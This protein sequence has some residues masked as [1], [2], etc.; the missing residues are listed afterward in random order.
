MGRDFTLKQKYTQE[1]VPKNGQFVHSYFLNACVD[2][3]GPIELLVE[4]RQQEVD[5]EH[6]NDGIGEG[7]AGSDYDNLSSLASYGDYSSYPDDTT[8]FGSYSGSSYGR[9]AEKL[10]YVGIRNQGATCYLNSLIQ[11]PFLEF[12]GFLILLD[13]I[14]DSR[15][16][17]CSLFMVGPFLLML[18]QQVI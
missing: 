11:V 12:S 3:P 4:L 13:F 16:S 1:V 9:S 18:K 17:L 2:S 10:P 15:I 5:L 8:G 7:E 6:S 14:H